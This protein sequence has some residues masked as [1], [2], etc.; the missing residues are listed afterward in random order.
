M[1][2]ITAVEADHQDTRG[3][4]GRSFNTDKLL[5]VYREWF[6]DEHVL[7]RLESAHHE[8]GVRVVPGG[9]EHQ[10]NIRI[11]KDQVGIGADPIEAESLL[12]L[13]RRDTLGRHDGPQAHVPVLLQDRQQGRARERAGTDEPDDDRLSLSQRHARRGRPNGRG[14]RS[15]NRYGF[16]RRGRER[17][18]YPE[19]LCLRIDQEL[20][21]ASRLLDP[22]PVGHEREGIDLALGDELQ[23]ALE[24]AR[25]GPADV[26]DRVVEALLLEGGVVASRTVR[27]GDGQLELLLVGDLAR[28]AERHETD[29]GDTTALA[30]H[31][32]RRD[33]RGVGRRGGGHDDAIHADAVGPG[34]RRRHLLVGGPG[35]GCLGAQDT[36]PIR[37]VG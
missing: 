12:R 25:L 33:H 30:A 2:G 22:E 7:A 9:D 17:K 16:A 21:R 27:A 36:R 8:V 13:E 23:E 31:A 29:G 1:R 11:G 14:R 19:R 15:I 20:V 34:E 4:R 24:V 26:G 5:F 10:M 6:L 28:Q 3:G 37:Q 35:S 32:G 18:N